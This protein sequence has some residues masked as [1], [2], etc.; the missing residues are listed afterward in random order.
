MIPRRV[1]LRGFLC[2][3]DEQEIDFGG[4]TLWML[5]GLNGSGKSAVFDAVTYAL[6][7][8]HRGGATGAA[9]LINKDSDGFAVEF[10]FLLDGDLYRVKRTL[11]RGAKGGTSATQ[12]VLRFR[13]AAEGARSGKWEPVP[14]TSRKTE[15]EAWVGAHIGLT[16][17][18]FTAS[19]LLLQGRA[20]RLLESTPR[21][22][23]DVLAGIVGL[24]RY[25]QLHERADER[26]KVLKSRVEEL[27][28]QIDATPKVDTEEFAAVEKR[29]GQATV[30]R[31]AARTA[32]E[33]WREIEVQAR[34]WAELTTQRAE[35]E[36][37]WQASQ[38]LIAEADT[39]ERDLN[40]LHEL[41]VAL[42]HLEAVIKFR[43][44]LAGSENKT[45]ALTLS[46][47]EYQEKL[48]AADHALDQA[49]KKRAALNKSIARNEQGQ[50]DL[51]GRLQQ[52]NTLLTKV[53]MFE[54][55]D[56]DVR[57]LDAELAGLP[58]DLDAQVARAQ[59]R[60][61]ELELLARAVPG[62]SRLLHARGDLAD[63][64][65][66]EAAAIDAE[67]GIK[68]AGEKL[69]AELSVLAP[70]LQALAAGREAADREATSAQAL[71]EHARR[72]LQ[73]FR[74]LHGAKVCRACGQPLTPEHFER[75]TS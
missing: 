11:R 31:D 61:D 17:E 20:E 32:L 47:N 53:E 50:R 43:A 14:D 48:A 55:H 22:R 56:A 12:Q 46:R 6:F 27:Q 70:Q 42:P 4:A 38:A 67:F 15:F 66:R 23:F 21:E 74:E 57:R 5:A 29:T 73:S 45:Q 72:E 3:R 52:L 16:F 37:R 60:H 54:S 44:D 26:R 35:L 49:K 19:V 24:D 18:T 64:K 40:R 25:I 39:I 28:T 36:K 51:S 7:G 41:R 9:E 58:A 59:E 30:E 2:Y 1:Y 13:P 10:D 62:L 65:T 63:A 34:R 71:L 69:T 75:E 8:H 33:S 68:A